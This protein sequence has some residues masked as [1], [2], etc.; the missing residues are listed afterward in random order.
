MKTI[1]NTLNHKLISIQIIAATIIMYVTSLYSTLNH[2]LIS[3]QIIA[4][5]I[6]VYVTSLYST[7]VSTIYISIY[8]LSYSTSFIIIYQ[9]YTPYI[10]LILIDI[11]IDTL[12]ETTYLIYIYIDPNLREYHWII[13]KHF[14][15]IIIIH[16]GRYV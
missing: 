3:I 10:Y 7:Y 15:V 6:I 12:V 5:T 9:Y 11:L 4:A 8:N 1:N 13:Y 14:Y 2:K 16:G